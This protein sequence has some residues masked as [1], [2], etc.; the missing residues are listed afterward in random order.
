MG[1]MTDNLRLA[2][3]LQKHQQQSHE[4]SSPAHTLLRVLGAL[5]CKTN[6]LFELQA[7]SVLLLPIS[8]D[9]LLNISCV[10]SVCLSPSSSS[11]SILL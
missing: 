1:V 3:L 10:L 6:R 5:C 2:Q 4:V 11:P 7:S 8:K 9:T